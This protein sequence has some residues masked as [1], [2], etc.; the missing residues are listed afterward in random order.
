[1]RTRPFLLLVFFIILVI[2]APM[3]CRKRSNGF[4][5]ALD[6]LQRE[7]RRKL[8]ALRMAGDE[9]AYLEYSRA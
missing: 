6:A 2:I 5:I 4:V 3:A 7:L 9:S 1:V 8:A